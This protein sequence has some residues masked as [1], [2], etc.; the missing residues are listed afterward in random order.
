[1]ETIN[2]IEALS[3]LAQESRLNIFRLLARNSSEGVAA[4]DIASEL[5]IPHNTL[6]S[7]LNTLKRSGLLTSKRHGRSIV[8]KINPNGVQ[9][10]L[11]Y[12]IHDC[13]DGN[14][15]MCIPFSNNK[16]KSL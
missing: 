13:C 12:L 1:M 8:Y 4:G 6:S 2:A 5:N 15:D 16:T 7:H 9:R 3:A 10:L 11:S 14:P